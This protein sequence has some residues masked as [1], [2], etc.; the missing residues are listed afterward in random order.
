MKQ[1]ISFLL[2][3]VI[4]LSSPGVHAADN[5]SITP[6]QL[7]MTVGECMTV[8]GT[9]PVSL[10]TPNMNPWSSSNPRI[11]SITAVKTS[12]S[13]YA[14]VIEKKGTIAANSAGVA[15][16]SFKNYVTGSTAYCTVTVYDKPTGVAL[17]TAGS[18]MTPNGTLSI[19]AKV[20]PSTAS[21]NV[22]W[23]SSNA[24]IASVDKNGRIKA[25]KPGSAVITAVTVYGGATQKKA[26]SCTIQVIEK[27]HF[28]MQCVNI[29]QGPGGSYSHKGSNAVDNIGA[30]AGVVENVFA[31]FTGKI[32]KIYGPTNSVWLESCNKVMF[33]DGTIDYMTVSFTH[34]MDISNLKLGMVIPKGTVFYQ[35]GTKSPSSKV[36]GVHLHFE[37]GKGK[38]TSPGWYQNSYGTWM[39]YNS[40]EPHKALFLKTDTLR[41]RDMGYSWVV[42]N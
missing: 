33:A 13:I 39:I 4:L 22:T 18:F 1:L 2:L 11:A 19:I 17:N 9:C 16:I 36:T 30:T 42:S 23:S 5:I 3:A 14:P 27:A 20:L 8:T 12:Q 7:S 21:Q 15:K 6:S 10:A 31:P 38:Y 40:I 37:C 24:S 35:E 29:S 25:L 28:P 32:V 34:D 26:A 41:K